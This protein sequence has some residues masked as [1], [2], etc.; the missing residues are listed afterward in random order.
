MSTSARTSERARVEF[1]ISEG[2]HSFLDIYGNLKIRLHH[3]HAINY[4][5]G[6]GGIFIPAFKSISQWDK[7]NRADLDV[8]GHFHQ[9]KDG[10]KF[11]CNGIADRL[12]RLR[13]EHQGGLRTAE[14][15][16]VPHRQEARAHLHVAHRVQPMKFTLADVLYCVG[17][18]CFL[19]GTVI[20]AWRR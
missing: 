13:A 10:G 3:G 18:L 17:S 20:N 12:Q 5:G 6:I 14:A 9:S 15:N 1:R 11:I 4:Q 2:Y 7:A 16:A 8:F 19:A